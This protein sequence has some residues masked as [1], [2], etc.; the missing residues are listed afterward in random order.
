MLHHASQTQNDHTVYRSEN[1]HFR[2]PKDPDKPEINKRPNVPRPSRGAIGN[3]NVTRARALVE[4]RRERLVLSAD[5]ECRLD[6]LL[7]TTLRHVDRRAGGGGGN[8]ELDTVGLANGRCGV[9]LALLDCT[10]DAATDL[11]LRDVGVVEVEAIKK[12]QTRGS[13]WKCDVDVRISTRALYVADRRKTALELDGRRHRDGGEEEEADDGL[14]LHIGRGVVRDLTKG[15]VRRRL[16]R[17][18]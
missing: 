11:E 4:R 17:L 3:V 15:G 6:A 8:R 10:G 5:L 12:R 1:I 14:E 16:R 13:V 2:T 7:P 9:T 18:G